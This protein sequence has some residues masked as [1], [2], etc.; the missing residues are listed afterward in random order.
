MTQSPDS[1]QLASL[2]AQHLQVACQQSGNYLR[3][4]ARG[5]SL[6][7]QVAHLRM[8]EKNLRLSAMFADLAAREE[9]E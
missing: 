3:K 1:A 5:Y 7:S 8:V 6:D 4:Y 2:A 9:A